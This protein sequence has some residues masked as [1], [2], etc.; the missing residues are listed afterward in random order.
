MEWAQ[1][2]LK[3][4]FFLRIDDDYFLCIEKLLHELTE[5]PQQK[6][7][8][9][10]WH[11]DK[12]TAV[13]VDESFML[14]TF[15]LVDLFM[16]FDEQTLL[17]HPFGDQQLALWLTNYSVKFTGFHDVRLHHNPPASKSTK[18][19]T[20]RNICE[21]YL[22]LH[23]TYPN[24]M[25][26]FWSVANDGPKKIPKL[27]SIYPFFCRSRPHYKWDAMKEQYRFKPEYCAKNP[28]WTRER[29][30]WEGRQTGGKKFS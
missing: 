8:W 21:V 14:L 23:G 15:D 24:E 4:K 10:S 16:S 22:G 18:L 29:E 28:R 7:V 1:A 13:F 20:M 9:G 11:C 12:P 27:S 3:P 25:R 19:K 17:C 2:K 5:R 30:A 6:L 26:T